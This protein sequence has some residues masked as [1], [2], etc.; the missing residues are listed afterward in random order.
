MDRSLASVVPDR[1]RRSY[2][3]KFRLVAVAVVLVI[4][5]IGGLTYV[6]TQAE[7]QSTTEERLET[8]AVSQSTALGAWVS[9]LRTDATLLTES[10]AVS[11]GDVATVDAYLDRKY[12]DGT[13]D[14]SVLAVH[15]LDTSEPVILASSNDQFVGVNPRERGVPWAQGG[16]NI[17]GDGPVVTDA[18]PGPKV[19]EPVVAVIAP[20]PDNSD[21]ALVLMINVGARAERLPS[22]SDAT[23][24]RV[25]NA[26]GTIVMSQR[27]S[28]I[29]TANSPATDGL[30]AP[31]QRALDSETG[32]AE[33]QANGTTTVMGYAPVEGVE[34]AVMTR[35]TRANAFALQQSISRNLMTVVAV[36]VLGF[37]VVG[38]LVGR[39]TAR[40][41]DELSDTALDIASGNVAREVTDSD[42][43]DELGDVQEAFQETRSYVRTVTEQ[44]E[45]LAAQEFDAEAF[46][47]DVPGTLG[48]A[49][50]ETRDDLR[51]SIEDIERARDEAEAARGEAERMADRLSDRAESFQA[52]M[53]AVADGDLT[54][55]LDTSAEDPAMADIAQST[56]EMLAE[57]ESTVTGVREFAVEVEQSTDAIAASIGEIETTSQ[58]VATTSQTIADG[59]AKQEQRLGDAVDE[60]SDLSATVEEIA[61]SSNEVAEQA[62]AAADLGREGCEQATAAAAEISD[63]ADR[64][65]AVATEVRRLDEEMERIGE[66]VVLIDEIADQTNLLAL[67]ANIEAARA[68]DGDATDGGE[69]FAVVANEVKTLAEETSAQTDEIGE[70]IRSVQASTS[71]LAADMDEA[72]D[73]MLG[74]AESVTETRE[75]FEDVVDR[76]EEAADG[77]RAID[78]ATDEQAT[79]TEELVGLVDEVSDVSSRTAD[80]TDDLAAA[81]EEQSASVSSVT[82]RI[83][84]LSDRADRLRQLTAEFTTGDTPDQQPPS[85]ER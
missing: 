4:A 83:D 81:A 54:Q 69:G 79:A 75:L 65:E 52:T 30:T 16:L 57:L 46:D 41:L 60:V 63:I 40:A 34:W 32:Y 11:T 37:L 3:L 38:L 77:I 74:G 53:A 19:D 85:P 43:I 28:E 62:T 17:G 31:L 29:L 14:P 23:Y 45:A 25:V 6:Q 80:G 71:G 20:V 35:T 44:V 47:G 64:V 21:R 61:A 15:Y 18:F 67:N 36:S 76:V 70:I 39:P 48:E 22:R 72:R 26:D 1:I 2:A 10:R 73:R 59:A 55:R 84:D 82:E 49:I 56:N 66:I 42:R 12:G 13:L 8:T 27:E 7:L 24:T 33:R 68:G 9:D 5:T 50:Q 78:G 58:E 51:R